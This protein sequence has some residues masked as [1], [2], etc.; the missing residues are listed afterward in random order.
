MGVGWGGVERHS[1]VDMERTAIE[2]A[3]LLRGIM[4]RAMVISKWSR[5]PSYNPS[6]GELKC[7]G[8]GRQRS[9]GVVWHTSA[10]VAGSDTSHHHNCK[11]CFCAG[12]LLDLLFAFSNS[13]HR[14]W[15]ELVPPGSTPVTPPDLSRHPARSSRIWTP[16]SSASRDRRRARGSAA[17]LSRPSPLWSPYRRR[18]VAPWVSAT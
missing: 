10:R 17:S 13:S 8:S 18:A 4:R 1:P 5:S 16:T 12:S 14:S 11:V 7:D 2:A 6:F 9:S 3:C 15:H